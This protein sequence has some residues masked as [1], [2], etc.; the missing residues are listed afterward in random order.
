MVKR[1]GQR[2]G[3][4]PRYLVWKEKASRTSGWLKCRARSLSTVLCG[5]SS[6][7][8]RSTSGWRKRKIDSNGFSSTGRKAFSLARFSVMKPRK[9]FAS[10]GQSL[11]ISASIRTGSAVASRLPAPSKNSRYSGSTRISLASSSS[12]APTL[13]KI[14][15]MT[16]G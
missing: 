7:R 13:S 12:R 11:A 10:S 15:A 6:G 14:S 8:L 9:P 16:R 5:R 4:I 2:N 3:D 1:L